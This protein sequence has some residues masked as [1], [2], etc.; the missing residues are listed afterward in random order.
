VKRKSLLTLIGASTGIALA[1][2]AITLVL[3]STGDGA[4][5]GHDPTAPAASSTTSST[6]AST[7][8]RAIPRAQRFR[9]SAQVAVALQAHGVAECAFDRIRTECRYHDGRYVAATV[10][11]EDFNLGMKTALQSWQT[12]LG[13]AMVGEDG[14]FA[15]LQGPNWLVTGPTELISAV[16]PEL[17]GNLIQCDHP[18]GTCRASKSR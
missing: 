1:A 11:T 10:I 15:I 12:G 8:P 17:G 18:N 2:V 13:Q 5:E 7:A 6:A 9:T 4:A 3:M 14:P 16:R